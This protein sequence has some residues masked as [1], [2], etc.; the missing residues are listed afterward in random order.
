MGEVIVWFC[1]IMTLEGCARFGLGQ[2]EASR[3]GVT[4][5]K[6]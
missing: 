5:P 1:L 3:E 4:Q 2:L 6:W